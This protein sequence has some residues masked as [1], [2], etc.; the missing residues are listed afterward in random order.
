MFVWARGSGRCGAGRIDAELCSAAGPACWCGQ[1]LIEA[2]AKANAKAVEAETYRRAK[3][4][5]R[6]K[7]HKKSAKAGKQVNI[8]TAIS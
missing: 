3:Q 5:V 4:K 7:A 8:K 2:N 6:S 1:A